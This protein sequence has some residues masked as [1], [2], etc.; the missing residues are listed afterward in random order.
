MSTG[1]YV[2][3]AKSAVKSTILGFGNLAADNDN[4]VMADARGTIPASTAVHD[5]SHYP[6]FSGGTQ[7]YFGNPIIVGATET[8]NGTANLALQT[9]GNMSK[10]ET[11][12][13]KYGR[14]HGVTAINAITGAVTYETL[15][16]S[17]YALSV[18]ITGVPVD[19]EV[20]AAADPYTV[21]ARLTYLGGNAP[22]VTSYNPIG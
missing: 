14:V 22:T 16:G 12:T 17:G 4:T 18:P 10:P 5:D 7:N 9:T 1:E 3:V 21:P 2:P 6:V 15:Q 20:D 11:H 8:I 19:K 13:R